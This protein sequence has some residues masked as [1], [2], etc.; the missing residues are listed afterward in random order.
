MPEVGLQRRFRHPEH[1]SPIGQRQPP[2]D[3]RE[4][5]A[6]IGEAMLAQLG[7]LDRR[8]DRRPAGSVRQRLPRF[9]R[10]DQPSEA[11]QQVRPIDADPRRVPRPIERLPP[12]STDA[13]GTCDG[14]AA[15]VRASARRPPRLLGEWHA[16]RRRRRRP[17]PP[18]A[19]SASGAGASSADRAASRHATASS[20][21]RSRRNARGEPGEIAARAPWP[22]PPGR[23]GPARAVTEQ[24]RRAS[25]RPRRCGGRRRRAA[26]PGRRAG[27]RDSGP[28]SPSRRRRRA[29]ADPSRLAL[30]R[31]SRASAIRWR[32][33]RRTIGSRS[34]WPACAGAGTARHPVAGDQQRPVEAAAVVGH[35]PAVG[36]DVARERVKH[37]RLVGVVGEQQLDLPE[38]VALPPAETDEERDGPGGRRE[39]GRLGVEAD[40]RDVRR[41]LAG[42]RARAAR[43][44]PGSTARPPRSRTKTPRGAST[45]S[46]STRGRRA[47]RRA[48]PAGRA[49]PT[50]AV[51]GRR[52]AA[53]TAGAWRAIAPV[54]RPGGRATRR[55]RSSRR[56]AA[57]GRPA[58]ELGEQPQR[59]RLARRRPARA[60]GRC[61]PGSRRRSRTRRSARRRRRP[62][63]RGAPTAA[64]TARSRRAPPR[65]G[66][67]SA[68]RACGER[69]CADEAEVARIDH[70]QDRRDRLD[71][72]PG[73]EQRDVELV[74]PPAG[75]AT[76]R[77]SA[78]RR[79]SGARARAGR[80]GP[81]RRSRR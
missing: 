79:S 26:R 72:P 28:G 57:R 54:A 78:S 71:R 19:T 44:R 23:R 67:S 15:E 36:R 64:R 70:Q 59:Q 6:D 22:G 8:D 5:T 35:E 17:E 38:P 21:R 12:S 30:D 74:A 3:R 31:P 40:Q 48:R 18:T 34:R 73:A 65:T 75:R 10:V 33:N 55:H 24:P 69:T 7:R 49:A 11:A 58:P 47:A 25:G 61:R 9:E 32:N 16:P 77:R 76:R 62:A 66:R 39:P 53:R 68:P 63:R 20:S 52:L 42:Q 51:R 27:T 13:A 29:G 45:T 41:R 60:A 56:P 4:G 1:P 50:A 14:A 37:G 81:S 2:L 43:G 80:S 46:P